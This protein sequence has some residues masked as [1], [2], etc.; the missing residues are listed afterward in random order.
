MNLKWIRFL[1]FWVFIKDHYEA[2]QYNQL[3]SS[4]GNNPRIYFTTKTIKQNKY[5]K[6]K[7]FSNDLLVCK[8][9]DKNYTHNRDNGGL[10]PNMAS[11]HTHPP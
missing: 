1:A 8:K 2:A 7:N 9:L 3:R 4:G 5:K 10:T 6:H 11:T